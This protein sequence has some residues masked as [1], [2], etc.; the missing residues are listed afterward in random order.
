M[1]R[2]YDQCA[3]PGWLD[4]DDFWRN[5]LSGRRACGLYADRWN[6]SRTSNLP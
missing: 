6:R 2:G 3:L 4:A 5:L 1:G